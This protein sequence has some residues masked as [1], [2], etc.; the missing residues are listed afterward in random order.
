[1][2]SAERTQALVGQILVKEDEY[3]RILPNQ[4]IQD[5]MFLLSTSSGTDESGDSDS[6]TNN[7]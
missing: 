6:D 5:I 2:K 1:M 4:S 3:N 7:T